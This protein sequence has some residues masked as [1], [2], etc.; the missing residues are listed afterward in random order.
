M[1]IILFHELDGIFFFFLTTSRGGKI[2]SKFS[3]GT[4]PHSDKALY[5]NVTST[6]T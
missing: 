1:D 2:E 4:I 3:N 6:G 5:F